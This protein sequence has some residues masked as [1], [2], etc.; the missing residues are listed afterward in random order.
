MKEKYRHPQFSTKG[1]VA[2]YK[3]WAGSFDGTNVFDYAQN[4]FVGVPANLNTEAYPGFAF[5]GT[6]DQ[7]DFPS[8]P[9]S[10]S[11]IVIWIKAN[12]ATLEELIDLNQT[13]YMEISTGD[14][15]SDGFAGGTVVIY[16]DAVAGTGIDTDWHM[17]T[18]TDTVGKDA[19]AGFMTLGVTVSGAAPLD[20][21]IGEVML[22]D[23][24]LSPA[25]VKSLYELS[26][27]RYPSN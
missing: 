9:T 24:V 13:D 3:L 10:V 8:G 4:G 23:R 26:K 19:S 17:V 25:E 1:L 12:G 2:Y 20:G 7:I 15:T 14:V 27:W 22:F 11:T 21:K 16:V 18:L 5:N 6:D